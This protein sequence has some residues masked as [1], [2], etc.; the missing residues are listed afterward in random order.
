MK[1]KTIYLS[2]AITGIPEN[3]AYQWRDEIEE[4]FNQIDL[5]WL[6]VFNPVTHFSKLGLDTGLYTDEDIMNLEIHKLRNSDIVFFNCHYPKSLG[7]MAEIAIAYE[8]GI[9]ILAFN[10]NNEEL[11]PWL[12]QMC[13]K[14]FKSKDDLIAYFVD[15]YMYD[16]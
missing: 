15:H 10:E 2:G 3:E 11:H 8:R 5:P 16:N 1:D 7:S 14:I 4:V 13:T 6:H 9:P 12:K